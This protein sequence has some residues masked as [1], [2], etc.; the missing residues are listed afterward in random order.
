[1]PILKNR[2]KVNTARKINGKTLNQ[3]IAYETRRRKAWHWGQP[4]FIKPVIH[5]EKFGDGLQLAYFGT[6]DQRPNYWLIRV[7][8]SIDF[9]TDDFNWEEILYDPLSECFGRYPYPGYLTYQ[10]F[11]KYRDDCDLREYESYKD[12]LNDLKYPAISIDC[13]VYW[14]SIANYGKTQT[15]KRNA[16]T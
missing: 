11:K 15:K 1:M 9:E 12:F 4:S 5:P 7:D 10:E 6:M 13:G 8:S 3:L 2:I 14:G 16:F